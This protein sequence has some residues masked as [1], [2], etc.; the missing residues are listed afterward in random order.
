MGGQETNGVADAIDFPPQTEDIGL[1]K[2]VPSTGGPTLLKE[3]IGEK[4]RDAIPDEKEKCD[5]QVEPQ[6]QEGVAQIEKEDNDQRFGS[7]P[8]VTLNSGRKIPLLGTGTASF[9]I[10]PI[11]D[12]KN[13]ILDA[14]EVGY[15]HFDSA[16]LYQSEEGLGVAIAEALEKGLIKSRDELFITTKLWCNN[17][18]P[19]R[20]LPAIHESLRK[21]RLEYV[22]LYLIHFPVRLKEVILDTTCEKDDIL[23]LDMKSTWE[24]MEEVHKIG[25]AKSIGVSNFTCK[26]L[27]DLLAH[28]KIPPAVNQV[29][30]HPVWQQQK[31]RDFCIEKGIHVSAYSPL[32][33]KEWGFDVVLGNALINDIARAKGKSV[34]QI[35][36]RWGFEQGVSLIPKSFNKGRLKQNFAIL[37]WQLTEEELQQI[38]TIPQKRVATIPEF[39]FP[40]GMF[41]S[42]EEFWDGE[43]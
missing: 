37:D 22:D 29:E 17:A 41:K 20:V 6:P 32:G 33:A 25:L 27:T 2:A 7:Q 8:T 16:A 30:M 24:A 34:A 12:L 35:A 13:A 18:C 5:T 38:G 42:P 11:E 36:L 31:L 1:A 3:V 14:M 10:P 4:V 21:L 28:A 9:P 43:M 26:K 15:R 39:I 40:D 19:E 23:P